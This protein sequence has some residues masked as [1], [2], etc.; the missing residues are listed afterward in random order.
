MSNTSATGGYLQPAASPAPLEGQTLDGFLQQVVALVV[1][2]DGTLVRPRWQ[3]EPANMPTGDWAALGVTRHVPDTYAY[4]DW[5]DATQTY[6]F[7]RHENIEV[8]VS[9]YG[10]NAGSNIDL[11]RDNL[12]VGQ[13]REVLLDNGMGLVDT[14]DVITAP[15]IIKQQWVMRK[16]MLITIRRIIQRSYPILTILSSQITL[17]TDEPPTTQQI[18]VT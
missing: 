10:P 16:D 12:Q 13:N 3:P 5:D 11:L 15:E 9:F 1:G 17:V 14:G 7:Q 4:T 6:A 18:N 8:L 2:M